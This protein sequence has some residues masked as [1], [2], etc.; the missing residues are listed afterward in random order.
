M[1][2]AL[3]LTRIDEYTIA[4]HESYLGLV[5]AIVDFYMVMKQT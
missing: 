4:H 5:T 2:A 3:E 1:L